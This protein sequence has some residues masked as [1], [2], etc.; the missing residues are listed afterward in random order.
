MTTSVK[1]FGHALAGTS[2]TPVVLYT[3]PASPVNALG[4]INV[5]WICNTDSATRKLTLRVGTGT[6]A[7]KDSLFEQWS[8]AA[9]RTEMYSSMQGLINVPAGSRVEIFDDTGGK[10]AVRIDGEEIY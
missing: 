3:A 5:M 10:V 4:Q 7:A 1:A 8:L 6:L 2:G 9:N